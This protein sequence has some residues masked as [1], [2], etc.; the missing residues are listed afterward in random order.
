MRLGPDQSRD[1]T[2]V[3][4][5]A[6]FYTEKIQLIVVLSLRLVDTERSV[7]SRFCA[8]HHEGLRYE[9]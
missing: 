9:A 7:G 2:T 4:V 5:I 1:R 8:S 3:L 6:M